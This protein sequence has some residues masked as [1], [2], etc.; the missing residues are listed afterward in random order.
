MDTIGLAITVLSLGIWIGLLAFRGQ[1][2]RADQRLVIEKFSARSVGKGESLPRVC[3][4]IPARNEAE[5][6]P[7]T[8][9]SLL[10]QDYPGCLT[11]ISGGLS[12]P[13]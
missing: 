10:A 5:L 3:A 8:L 12:A 9:R 6:L 7:T 2:W 1:F 11:L 13:G 4:V